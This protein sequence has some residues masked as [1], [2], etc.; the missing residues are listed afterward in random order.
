MPRFLPGKREIV[1][2]WGWPEEWQSWNW[3]GHEGELMDVRVFSR[4]PVVRLELNGR[5]IGEKDIN[6]STKLIA[7]FQVPYQPGLL[8]AVGLE[9]GIEVASKV[10]ATTGKPRQIKLTADRTV[11]HASRNDLSYV[12]IE[13]TDEFGNTIPDAAAV[14][15]L[16][17]TG[18]G[19]LAGVGSACPNC[20]ASFKGTEVKTFRGVALAILRPT[21]GNKTGNI[22]L[23]AQSDGLEQVELMIQTK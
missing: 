10:I 18:E 3:T 9:N 11:I 23:K 16:S 22:V 5:I 19:E 12:K 17:I 1:S 2:A 20:M 21:I 7:N 15:K 8:K 4:C 6:D 13:V 14:V